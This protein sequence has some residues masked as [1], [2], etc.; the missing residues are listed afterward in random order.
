M[1]SSTMIVS[2]PL[3]LILTGASAILHWHPVSAKLYNRTVDDSLGV[4]ETG[5]P[6]SPH[7]IT[8]QGRW[9]DQCGPV[10]NVVNSSLAYNGTL[11]DATSTSPDDIQSV[12]IHFSGCH[13][14]ISL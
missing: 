1:F 11:H 3:S 5:N 8:Y 12:T 13:I 4:V 2:H 9:S 14:L 10:C 6:E 7:N